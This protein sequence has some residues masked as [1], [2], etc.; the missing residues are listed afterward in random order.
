[1]TSLPEG[2]KLT[3]AGDEPIYSNGGL[4]I[5]T[6][7]DDERGSGEDQRLNLVLEDVSAMG[8][9]RIKAAV[10]LHR[11]ST[12]EEVVGLVPGEGGGKVSLYY[13]EAGLRNS[14]RPI[15]VGDSGESVEDTLA[16]ACSPDGAKGH[17]IYYARGGGCFP[18]LHPVS[19]FY[20]G[21]AYA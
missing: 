16:R 21:I 6:R 3:W 12:W 13:Y 18:T 2:T 8:G 7:G 20:G 11:G 10:N 17:C 5:L 14:L 1:M 19:D 9:D 15:N 4:V